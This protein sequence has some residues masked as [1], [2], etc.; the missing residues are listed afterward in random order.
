[1]PESRVHFDTCASLCTDEPHGECDV[2][3]SCWCADGGL[4]YEEYQAKHP[5]RAKWQAW[6]A[7]REAEARASEESRA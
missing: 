7:K 6:E 3:H 4:S 2:E 1:M 5:V